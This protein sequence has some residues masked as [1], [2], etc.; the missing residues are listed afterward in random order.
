VETGPVTAF[1]LT[2][3]QQEFAERVREIA[4]RQLR[5]LA[6]AGTPGRVNRELVKAIQRTII[7]RELY[8]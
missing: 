7:A 8:R 3:E 1:G 2:G 5:P 4:A 6:Q